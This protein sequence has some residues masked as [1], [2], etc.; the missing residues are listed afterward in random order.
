MDRTDYNNM[1][2]TE[3]ILC[4][5]TT[6]NEFYAKKAKLVELCNEIEEIQNRYNAIEKEISIRKNIF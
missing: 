2:N 5:E 1:T 4:K 3:L 6:L